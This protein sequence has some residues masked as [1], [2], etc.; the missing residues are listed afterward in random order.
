MS[1]DDVLER[2]RE[3]YD[4][5]AWSAA[6]SDLSAADRQAALGPDDLERL[7]IAAHL[8]GADGDGELWARAYRGYLDDD[9]LED[10][11]RCGFWVGFLHLLAGESARGSGWLH[12]AQRLVDGT[13]RDCAV[14]GYLLVP[15]AL[16]SLGGG[17]AGHAYDL[18]RQAVEIAERCADI[19]L[20][21]IGRLG[22]GQALV[23]RGDEVAGV[24][25]LD[26]VM[27]AVTSGE[28]S[29]IVA[30]I[31][32]CGVIE[33]CQE[34]FDLR[35]AREWT[36][37]L[38]RWCESQ[39]DLVPY[40]G[41]CLVHRAEIMQ[42]N[43]S[44]PDAINEVREACERFLVPHGH[45]A[46]GAAYYQ[47]AELHRLRGDYGLAEEA[48]RQANHWG[49]APQPGLA[50][51]RLTQGHAGAAAAA[52]R[53]AVGAEHERVRRPRLL[54]AY[55][56][57]MLAVD[58]IDAAREG[59]GE[60]STLVDDLSAPFLQATAAQAAGAVALAADDAEAA[61]AALRLAL[62]T[63]HQ[64]DAPYEVARARVLVALACRKLGDADTAELELDA[65]RAVFEHLGAVPDLERVRTLVGAPTGDE[66]ATAPRPGRPVAAGGLTARELEVLRLVASGRTNRAIAQEL[67]LSE[68]TV[69][70]HVSNIFGKLR[71]SSRSA[72]TAYAYEH[73]LV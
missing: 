22:C 21:A 53:R 47:R 1:R 36:A 42:V 20:L 46:A 32:Y 57:I 23:A 2:G 8:I 70:R 33:A 44:W 68:K 29:T 5:H 55:V 45:A 58:D 3:S 41:Q 54:A 31:V 28:V 49:R 14:R 4:R 34:I 40:R 39:P 24:A 25:L 48:Y 65:A 12:R 26:E 17:E 38:T 72:A 35:R 18:F 37:A 56:D 43:G 71:L 30:G 59:A 7:A 63:W 9:C 10:A 67:V 62:S 51:L 66:A 27:V 16:Q 69:A 64:L 73:D 6:H 61:L 13:G 52:I 11:A 15:A 60:L 50:Q 19:D